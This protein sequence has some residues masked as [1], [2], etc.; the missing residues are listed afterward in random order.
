MLVYDHAEELAEWL[1]SRLGITFIQPYVTIGV[2]RGWDLVAVVLY[3]QFE[4]PNIHVTFATTTPRWASRQ[5]IGRLLAYPFHELG[6]LRISAITRVTNQPTR[7]FLR[8]LGFRQEGFH[9]Q[10]YADDDGVSYGLLKSDAMK[11]I[12]DSNEQRWRINSASGG[13]VS[14]GERPVPE[15]HPDGFD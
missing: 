6:C 1:G 9:P 11:W 3:N 10:Y 5:V 14:G 8:R 4:P 2:V 12:E 13:P 15:Q 7:V